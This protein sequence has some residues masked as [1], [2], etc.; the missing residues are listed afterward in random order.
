MLNTTDRA[1]SIRSSCPADWARISAVNDKS[2]I[3]H[4]DGIET[5]LS[6]SVTLAVFTDTM[7]RFGVSCRS[8]ISDKTLA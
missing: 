3:T 6:V 1:K 2:S 8:F 7:I 4:C 5:T